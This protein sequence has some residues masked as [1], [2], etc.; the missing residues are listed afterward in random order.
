LRCLRPP[1]PYPLLAP[2]LRPF[3]AALLA[4]C[5][6]VT[7]LL[8]AWFTHQA[9][10][11]RLDA[12]VDRRIQASLGGHPGILD[13]LAGLGDKVPVTVMTVALVLICLATRRPRGAALVAVAVPTA[14]ALT[15][16]LLKPLI[17]RTMRGALSFPSGHSTGAFAV[18]G[19]CA[20]LL[21]GPS[22]PGMRAAARLLLTLAAYLAACAVAVA[23]IGLGA[24]YLTDTI[25]GAA[26]GTAAVLVTA[27]ILDRLGPPE[28]LRVAA[29]GLP[30]GRPVDRGDWPG[31]TGQSTGSHIRCSR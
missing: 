13:V 2:A 19:A 10:P 20:V 8:G 1:V 24:H 26:V 28:H 17:G 25:A 27:F 16:L 21:A 15:E 18:A 14:A 12:A 31:H 4:V 23:L 9:R 5:L 30:P 22:R 3:A 11:G 29:G 6:A 7:V